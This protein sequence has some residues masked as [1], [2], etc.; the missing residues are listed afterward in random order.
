M[1]I[2]KFINPF[3]KLEKNPDGPRFVI[4]KRYQVDIPFRE[5]DEKRPFRILSYLQNRRLLKKGMLRRPRPVSL[6]R[7]ALVHGQEYLHTLEIPGAMESVLGIPLD[8]KTQDRFLCFQRMMCGGTVRAASLALK[9]EDVAVNLGGGFHHAMANKGSGF[10]VFNDIAVAVASLRSKGH[11]F[12]ILII[13]LDLHDGDGTRSIFADDATVHTYSIHNRTLDEEPAIAN[14]TIELGADVDDKTYLDSLHGSLP[15]VIEDVSPGLVF[16]LAGSDPNIDDKLGNWRITMDGM[17]ARDIFVMG[18]LRESNKIPT[19]IVLGGG[20]GKSAWRPSAAFFSWLLSGNSN[21]DIPMELELPVGHYRRLTSLMINSKLHPDEMPREKGGASEKTKSA[22]NDDWG[23]N[24][25]DL[26]AGLTPENSLFLGQFSRHGIELALEEYGLM[27]QLRGRGY[28]ELR[29]AIDLSD[30]MGHFL[31][32]QTGGSEPEVLMEMRLRIDKTS[33]Q[34]CS[35]LSIEWLLI[36]DAASRFELS[37][38][39]LPGQK[40]P[41]LGL[42]RDTAAV[43]VVVAERLGLDGLVY[44]PSQYH[45]ARLGVDLAWCLDPGDQ[46]RFQAVQDVLAGLRLR[47]AAEA[48]NTGK[49]VDEKTNEMWNWVPVQQVIPV[50]SSMK[51]YF[52]SQDYRATAD[53]IKNESDFKMRP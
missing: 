21:L 17:L 4:H 47:E 34:G 43:L 40:H 46:G 37:E 51:T 52:K 38:K 18:L 33:K 35:F 14:T 20:Y 41:G 9:R 29:V 1:E 16:F 31:R 6:K 15:A 26:G 36:Q 10:C 5:Y 23:L 13:D 8:Q 3:R 39:L 27:D 49:I 11:Q 22:T 44:T 42:L 2:L 28:R 19:A 48:I 50:S 32:I 45:L 25:D 53:R 30:P 12:P 24:E 7:L